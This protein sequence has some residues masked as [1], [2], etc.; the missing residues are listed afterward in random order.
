MKTILIAALLLVTT[1]AFAGQV[2]RCHSSGDEKDCVTKNELPSEEDIAEA[3]HLTN[4]WSRRE[5]WRKAHCK[6]LGYGPHTNEVG[7]LT[8]FYEFHQCELPY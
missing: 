6:E 2:T 3:H 8:G 4:F 1:P 5:D 7:L